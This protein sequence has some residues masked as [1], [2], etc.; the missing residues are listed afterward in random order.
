MSL[1]YLKDVTDLTLDRDLCNG[2]RMCI[3]VCPHNVFVLSDKKALIVDKDS[4]MGCGACKLN[5]PVNAI[6]VSSGVGCAYA[7]YFSALTKKPPTC[8]AAERGTPTC[9]PVESGAGCGCG[10]TGKSAGHSG[11]AEK[12]DGAAKERGAPTCC[13]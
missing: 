2:C 9:G 3:N 1:Q 4:C 6:S 5:C 13:G 12:Q 10:A 8:G 11:A 7:V